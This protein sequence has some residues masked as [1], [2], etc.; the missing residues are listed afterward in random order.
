MRTSADALRSVL[1]DI[2]DCWKVEARKLDLA[3]LAF[4]PG[5]GIADA[6]KPFALRAHQKGRGISCEIAPDVP[7]GIVGDAARI[8][9][10]LT[11]LIGNAL[12]FTARGHVLVSVREESRAAG[13]TTLHFAVTDTGIGIPV[14]KQGV[15]FDAFQQADGSTTRRFGGTGLGLTISATLVGLMGGRLWVE[16]TPNAGSTFHF[17]AAFDV[18]NA[19]EAPAPALRMAY[20]NVLIIDDNEV[21]RRIF[22]EQ[23]T[24]W[25][26]T[27]TAVA[28]GRAG[29]DAWPRRRPPAGPARR[30]HAGH[31]RVRGRGRSGDASRAERRD[32]HD[33]E[34][35]R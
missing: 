35:V 26:M 30:E 33:A 32:D 7:A 15:I 17:T 12:K 22:V 27:A 23:V 4:A 16:S 8:Q 18:T 21:N 5:S 6:L 19:P 1:T 14:E 10:V 20:L 3:A 25:G 28:S 13:R 29:I 9:Q 34:L 11:N 31:G 24:R 2:L